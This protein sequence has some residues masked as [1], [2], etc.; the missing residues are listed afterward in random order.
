M[1]GRSDIQNAIRPKVARCRSKQRSWM[2]AFACEKSSHGWPFWSR[3]KNKA[4]HGALAG[5]EAAFRD[6]RTTID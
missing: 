6:E 4:V 1:D 3:R 2:N 5:N